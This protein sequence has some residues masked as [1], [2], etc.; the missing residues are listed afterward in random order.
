MIVAYRNGAPVRIRDIGVA[1]DGPENTQLAA[2]QN[3]RPGIML[4]IFKQ[5]GANI[6]D[7]VKQIDELLPQILQSVPPS[8][9]VDR[10]IDRT[11]TINAS[12]HD[13]ELTLADHGGAGRDRDLPVPAERVGDDHSG[14]DRAVVVARHVCRDVRAGL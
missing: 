1:V 10:L 2:W 13:V 8:I 11:Q 7:T 9:K 5:P 4:Q 12:V 3:G 6:I 14:T